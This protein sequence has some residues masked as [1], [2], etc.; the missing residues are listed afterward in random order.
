MHKLV[1]EYL[2]KKAKETLETDQKKKD[3]LLIKSGLFEKEYSTDEFDS[4][5][6]PEC[7]RDPET[8]R[9]RYYK[10][11]PIEVSDEE[12]SEILKYQKHTEPEYKEHNTVAIIFKV[13]AWVVFIVGFIAGIVLGQKE[14]AGYY[15]YHTEFSFLSALKYW[16][17]SFVA[18]M[19]YLGFAEIIQLLHDIKGKK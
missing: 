19:I 16:I 1:E 11:I 9:S 12:Y 8:G 3:E 5:E 10:K 18:G 13:F 4:D 14:V 15:S 7:E 17:S 6:Y 2:T